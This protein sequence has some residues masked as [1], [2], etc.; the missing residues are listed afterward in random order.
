MS[1]TPFCGNYIVDFP[2]IVWSKFK[3]YSDMINC[4]VFKSCSD[5]VMVCDD[6]DG[7]RG[8]F[9]YNG[10]EYTIRTWNIRETPTG[11]TVE[12]SIYN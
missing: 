7:R 2:E 6:N 3:S 10:I 1:V 12:Y 9:T 11:A 8:Y 4:I 5:A